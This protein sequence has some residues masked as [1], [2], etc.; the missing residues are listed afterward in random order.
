MYVLYI[1]AVFRYILAVL[2]IYNSLYIYYRFSVLAVYIQ[3]NFYK[4]P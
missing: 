4:I 3:H 1:L 2:I